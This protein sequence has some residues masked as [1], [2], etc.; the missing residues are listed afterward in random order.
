MNGYYFEI[1][2]VD[3]IWHNVYAGDDSDWSTMRKAYESEIDQMIQMV[4]KHVAQ[5]LYSI[6]SLNATK[7]SL[8][9]NCACEKMKSEVLDAMF[10]EPNEQE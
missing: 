10:S 2:G 3:V 8:T 5:G 9:V 1:Y 7:H 6:I 4:G